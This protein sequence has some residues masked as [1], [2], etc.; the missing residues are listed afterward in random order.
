[1]KKQEQT[2]QKSH[3]IGEDIEV[4]KLICYMTPIEVMKYIKAK[5]IKYGRSRKDVYLDDEGMFLYIK[6]NCKKYPA[7]VAHADTVRDIQ[8]VAKDLD[9]IYEFYFDEKEKVLWSPQLAGFDDRAGI[10]AISRLIETGYSFPILILN[11]EEIGGKG[12]LAFCDKFMEIDGESRFK[13]FIELDRRGFD[14]SV[15]YNCKN[16]FFEFYIN[17]FGFNTAQG[18]FSDIYFLAPAFNCAAVNLSIGYEDEHTVAERLYL[19][20]FYDTIKKV[21]QMLKTSGKAPYFKYF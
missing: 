11:Q 2:E 14:D 13:Y 7:L 6:G 20:A 17:S 15:F 4:L 16:S 12:A 18:L 10:L 1:M 8:L 21:E 9:P 3:S 19:D 5:A